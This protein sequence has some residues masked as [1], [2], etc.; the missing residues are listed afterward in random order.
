MKAMILAAGFGTRLKP[1][2]N[3][4]PKALIEIRGK[5]L[6]EI[7]IN[8]LKQEGFTDIIINVHH[9]ANQIIDFLQENNN[10]NINIQISNESEILLNTG[11]GIYNA[12]W[13]FENEK[14]FLV[15]NVDIISDINLKEL[16]N[17]HIKSNAIATLAV[18]NRKTSRQLLFDKDKNLC[19]WKNV[20]N[21]EEKI[22]RTT[23]SELFPF[24]FSGIHV[25]DTSIFN[26]IKER[27]EFSIIDV[28]LRLAAEYQIKYYNHKNTSWK[29]MG[30]YEHVIKYNN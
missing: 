15:Y 20:I 29:D 26:L 4:K 22:S 27:G 19:K 3:N 25:I 7:A 17:F 8:K 28:Y 14:E 5:T 12:K 11:G 30:K 13:F 1:L 10:F 6:L 23:N 18:K 16:Y 24:A 21:G 2:T 9:F